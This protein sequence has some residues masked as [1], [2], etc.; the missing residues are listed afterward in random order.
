MSAGNSEFTYSARRHIDTRIYVFHKFINKCKYERNGRLMMNR[1]TKQWETND[2]MLSACVHLVYIDDVCESLKM[3]SRFVIWSQRMPDI[4]TMAMTSTSTSNRRATTIHFFS[5]FNYARTL[6]AK[7]SSTSPIK[8][9]TN[10]IHWPPPLAHKCRAIA[11]NR[12]IWRQWNR[13]H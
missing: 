8:I 12:P 3:I 5:T 2:K 4:F 9:R 11:T 10:I 6:Y 7:C 13:S 1:A